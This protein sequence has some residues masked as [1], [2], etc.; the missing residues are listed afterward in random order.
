MKKE[1]YVYIMTNQSNTTLY[2]GVTN[3]L[4]RRVLEHKSGLGSIFTSKYRLKKLVYFEFFSD[5]NDA[6][7]REKQLKN[8]H[9][10]WKLNL[11]HVENSA[12]RDLC[13]DPE[14]IDP[15]TSSG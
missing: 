3:N 5:V 15:E 6:I 1:Y 11:I 13:M 9:R 12:M 4:Q 2:I 14:A 10:Q 8:W 7:R